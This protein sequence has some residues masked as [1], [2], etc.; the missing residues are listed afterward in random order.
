[1]KKNLLTILLTSL[2]AFTFG[3]FSTGVVNLTP[4]RTI[5]IDTNATNVVM[6]LTAPSNVWFGVGFGGFSMAE[7]SDMFI[8]SASPNRDYMAPGGHFTPSADAANAQSWTIVSDNVISNVRTVVATRA[9][10]SGGD[11]TFLNNN[12]S[13]TIIYA[14]G[15]ST[16]LSNHGTN[17]HDILTLQRTVLGTEKFSLN[18]AAVYPNPSK[19]LFS[20]ESK[21]NI[22][23]I[24]VYSHT[25]VF[26][27]TIDA[28][29]KSNS[30]KLDLTNLQTGVYLIELNSGTEK[31]WKKI[32]I[33]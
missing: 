9:L 29:E 22:D 6:T 1:M 4:S 13:I 2:S 15:S 18:D 31:S 20:I 5:R 7:V 30:V 11:Y 33:E 27:K 12:S 23:K 16:T 10:V 24:N 8:W 28:F 3:Q 21:T 32:V 14:Q 17:P 19:G 26:V 25:G